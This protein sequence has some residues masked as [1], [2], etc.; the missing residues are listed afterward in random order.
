MFHI[1][2]LSRNAIIIITCYPYM[3]TKKMEKEKNERR[4]K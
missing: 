2:R 1:E 3:V 4:R